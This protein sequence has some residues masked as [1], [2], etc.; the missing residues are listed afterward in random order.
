MTDIYFEQL[1][2]VKRTAKDYILYMLVCFTA[3]AVSIAAL[4]FALLYRIALLT[5]AA[6]G[7]MYG[8]YYLMRKFGT[9]YEY[10]FT[11]GDLDFDKIT[12][13]QTR[14]HLITADCSKIIKA[15]NYTGG[16]T[17]PCDLK[18]TCCAKDAEEQY[19]ILFNHKT[20]GKVM[21][22]FTPNNNIKTAIHNSVARHMQ[23]SVFGE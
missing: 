17:V 18:L 14:K 6:A 15:G 16:D 11:N 4:Y 23:Q 3:A 7:A 19:Y 12:G 2:T 21:V 22:I 8:A 13:R 20:A 9:E 10:I 1:V 5:L